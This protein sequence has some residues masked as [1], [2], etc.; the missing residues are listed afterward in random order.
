MGPI[1][2]KAN[3]YAIE[4][5]QE[6]Y[7]ASV[8]STGYNISLLVLVDDLSFPIAPRNRSMLQLL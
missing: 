4:N 7:D 1:V 2:E 8:L 5:S 6:L 3:K